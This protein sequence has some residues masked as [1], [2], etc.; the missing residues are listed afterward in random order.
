MGKNY[1]NSQAT[2]AL[3]FINFYFRQNKGSILKASVDYIRKLKKDQ[4]EVKRT[5]LENRKLL[6]KVQVGLVY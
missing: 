5:K 2:V 6:L 1:F 3:S 4:E